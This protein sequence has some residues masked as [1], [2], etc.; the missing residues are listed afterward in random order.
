RIIAMEESWTTEGTFTSPNIVISNDYHHHDEVLGA[1]FKNWKSSAA[2]I[3]I[4]L[5]GDG[6]E[7]TD[8]RTEE[9]LFDIDSDGIAE[10]MLGWSA[11][12]DGL[13]AFDYDQDGKITKGDEIAFADYH[14]DANTDLEGLALAFDAN[15][16]GVFDAE[17]QE[18][19]KFG[20]WQDKDQNGI[21]DEGEWTGIEDTGITSFDM[22]SDGELVQTDTSTIYG[23]GNYT[24]EDGSEGEF[25]DTAF[26]FEEVEETEEADLLTLTDE[27]IYEAP[28]ND[29][30][31]IPDEDPMIIDME[32]L[33]ITDDSG[34]IVEEDP[35]DVEEDPIDG[36]MAEVNQTLFN[37]AS[38]AASAPSDPDLEAQL[39]PSEMLD[40]F[41][42]DE[43]KDEQEN[44]FF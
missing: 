26:L 20:I 37:S 6:V 22:N 24:N 36:L 34:S 18:W 17:D 11:A 21:C 39:L 16:D 14:E 35:I 8:G 31:V 10:Q 43:E 5:D 40:L 1:T 13:L 38:M 33:I 7:L 41:P 30:A 2:P 3:V 27:F 42:L 23:T 32:D 25:T 19:E 9:I 44:L 12:D 28:E 29:P 4:D 15:Q